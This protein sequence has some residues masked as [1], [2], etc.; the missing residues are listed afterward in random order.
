MRRWLAPLAIA[1]VLG[2]CT[3]KAPE[4]QGRA[5][6]VEVS[7]PRERSVRQPGMSA[8]AQRALAKHGIKPHDTSPV[9]VS[10]KC[11]RVDE[12]GTSTR[13]NLAVSDGAV[14]DFRA[15]VAIKGRGTC[16]FALADFHQESRTPQVLLRHSRDAKCTV[17]MWREQTEKITIAFNG[18]HKSC[19]GRAF[20]YLWPIL[21]ESESGQC[22]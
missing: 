2:A 13:L 6:E 15:D 21:V 20:D 19:D 9:T 4:E 8:A 18:C 5:D 7:K 3:T 11:S 1:L 16:R 10:S 14:S 22:F 12:I 17:R